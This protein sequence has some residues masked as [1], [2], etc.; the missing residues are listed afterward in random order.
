MVG[1]DKPNFMITEKEVLEK[2]KDEQIE[3]I[4]RL[5]V[6]QRF[7]IWKKLKEPKNDNVIKIEAK[8]S[9]DIINREKLL[10]V[11]KEMLNGTKKENS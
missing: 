8:N 10:E 11:V 9:L 4:T 5:K 3:E 1:G 2:I 6:N 7:L